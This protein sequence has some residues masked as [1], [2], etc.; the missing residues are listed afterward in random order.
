MVF[1][2]LDYSY[3]SHAQARDRVHRI[4]Q[5]KSCLYLYI[6]AR[7]TIDEELMK[8]LQRKKGLQEAVYVLVGNKTKKSGH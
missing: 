7:D 5:K 8:V 3:E 4:G 6:V 2:S 1:Y